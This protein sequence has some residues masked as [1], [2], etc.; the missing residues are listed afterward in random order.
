MKKKSTL[1]MSS[2]IL[3]AALF[4]QGAFAEE[5]TV[6]AADSTSTVTES[7]AAT[8][9]TATEETATEET[10]TE[11]A[12]TEEVST[13]EATVGS[14]AGTKKVI[15]NDLVTEYVASYQGINRPQGSWM[16]MPSKDEYVILVN[17]YTPVTSEGASWFMFA[18]ETDKNN[19]E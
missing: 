15:D 17:D 2:L 1:M 12:A 11:E 18:P 3:G 4:T 16:T 13:P 10:A 14:E 7:G 5:A 19:D 8:E 9:E 6:N